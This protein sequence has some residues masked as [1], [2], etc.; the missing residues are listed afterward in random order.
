MEHGALSCF[1]NDY[2]G[3]LNM[4]ILQYKRQINIITAIAEQDV[5]FWWIGQVGEWSD[6]KQK[7][8]SVRLTLYKNV[9]ASIKISKAV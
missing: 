1:T 7:W 9:I 2:R 8:K 5:W 3:Y 4:Y 6:M